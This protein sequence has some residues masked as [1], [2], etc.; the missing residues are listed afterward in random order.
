MEATKF[1]KLN[2]FIL[3]WLGILTGAVVVGLIFA[4]RMQSLELQTSV[5]NRAITAPTSTTRIQ[6]KTVA[7]LTT[8][9]TSLKSSPTPQ[10]YSPTPQP[11]S[12][13]PQPYSGY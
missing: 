9:T 12:P 2:P 4:Y 7:P 3:F 13:T 10:P 5:M 6:N 8:E 11:Y 1:S